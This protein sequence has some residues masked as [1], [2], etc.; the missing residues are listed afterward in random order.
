MSQEEIE[1]EVNE[2]S[3]VIE[4]TALSSEEYTVVEVHMD[5]GWPLNVYYS[6]YINSKVEGETTQKVKKTDVEIIISE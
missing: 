3:D 1:K 6:R 5:T 4:Q 2:S